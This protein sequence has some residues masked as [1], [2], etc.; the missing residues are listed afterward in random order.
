MRFHASIDTKIGST[1]KYTHNVKY[2]H[3][4]LKDKEMWSIH[5]KYTNQN[6]SMSKTWDPDRDLI[7]V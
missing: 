2:K 4:F 7:Y 5:K 3:L 1:Y 6:I